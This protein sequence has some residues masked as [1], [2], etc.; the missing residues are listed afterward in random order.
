[1][2][3]NIS[4]DE[5]HSLLEGQWMEVR[6]ESPDGTS[7]LPPYI[8]I[9]FKN[10]EKF[11]VKSYIKN[12]A[13]ISGKYAI[14]D[15]ILTFQGRANRAMANIISERRFQI[16]KL[17][18]DLL[19]LKSFIGNSDIPKI[20]YTFIS[21]E[22]YHALDENEIKNQYS[23]T[24]Q[25]TLNKIENRK[26]YREEKERR[27][28]DRFTPHYIGGEEA[29][30]QF[31]SAN[32]KYPPNHFKRKLVL[33]DFM[34]SKDGKI[35][36]ILTNSREVNFYSTEAIRLVNSMKNWRPAI[37]NGEAQ[38]RRYQIL[39]NFKVSNQNG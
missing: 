3:S 5:S 27:K 39:I 9:H 33:V 12:G 17:E 30:K 38:D 10:K 8:Y 21:L 28:N 36:D 13:T 23:F 18:K 37:I 32:L 6:K 22:K 1:M 31:I 19:I 26:R 15:S 7:V 2:L 4:C 29:M 25:D 34:V 11:E 24:S 20:V 14:N 35:T 16:L